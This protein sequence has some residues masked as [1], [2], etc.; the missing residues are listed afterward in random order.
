MMGMAWRRRGGGGGRGG[1][2][3]PCAAFVVGMRSSRSDSDM[4]LGNPDAQ[5]MLVFF[6]SI[7]PNMQLQLHSCVAIAPYLLNRQQEA[8][9]KKTDRA[10]RG[11]LVPQ[12]PKKYQDWL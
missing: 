2:K 6:I 8:L 3:E 5:G 10:L 12:R 11:W 9:Q 1:G 7:T 4:P